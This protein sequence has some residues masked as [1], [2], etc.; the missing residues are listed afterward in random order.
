VTLP[1][2]NDISNDPDMS[3]AKDQAWFTAFIASLNQDI[4][5]AKI[6]AESE[7]EAKILANE[8]KKLKKVT[9]DSNYY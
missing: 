4:I 3:S 1:A 8:Q 5:D 2:I 6:K 7:A 9:K